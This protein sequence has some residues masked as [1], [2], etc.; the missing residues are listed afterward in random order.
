MK[1][2]SLV[3]AC[4][5]AVFLGLSLASA[6]AA[7]PQ[8]NLLM[9]TGVVGAL[10]YVFG[11]A[12][13]DVVEKHA[14]IKI[15]NLPQ[16]NVQT[17]P[18]LA[19]GEMD[20]VFLANDELGFAYL[21]EGIFGRQTKG[22]GYDIRLLMLGMRN[23]ASTVVRRDSG[24]LTYEDLRG[25]RVVLDF[26]TQ[27]ALN[28]GSRVSLIAGGLTE[29]DVIVSRAADIPA[30]VQL[31]KE[32]KVD[33][34]FGGI[35]V[36]V[37]RELA[38]AGG[39]IRYLAPNKKYMEEVN[40]ISRAYFL[41]TVKKGPPGI[42]ED[43]DLVTRNFV[44]ASRA[45]L[46]D[47]LAYRIVKAV[48]ENDRELAPKHPQLADWVKEHFVGEQATAPYH[49][50]AIRFYREKGVWTPRMQARQE[51]LLRMKK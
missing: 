23:A 41:M 26:G 10:N 18:L 27:Q 3:C 6:W 42:D 25:K 24:I 29:K 21:G 30:C 16:G 8:R 50:G 4:L 47:D 36:P 37:F 43:I 38:A 19:T 32:K 20:L 49:P 1:R 34:C 35:G 7:Q 39:G 11:A 5:A 48:W 31:L 17:M 45:N 40:K 2:K 13:C 9:G 14:G 44:I 51:E 28:L 22:K 46:P 15:E 33:A 12:I